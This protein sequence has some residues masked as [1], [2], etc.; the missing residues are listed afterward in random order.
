MWV[1]GGPVFVC[2]TIKQKNR[3][4]K[5]F[6]NTSFCCD[7]SSVFS[8]FVLK[9]LFSE[10]HSY[11]FYVGLKNILL[12]LNLLIMEML[13]VRRM[14]NTSDFY[15]DVSAHFDVFIWIS[16]PDEPPEGT[17]KATNV[18]ITFI[19]FYFIFIFLQYSV[20]F[21]EILKTFFPWLLKKDEFIENKW[22]ITH[23]GQSYVYKMIKW[24]SR[25]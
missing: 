15:S 21:K 8:M 22:R 24:N 1:C 13:S 19:V 17:K 16:G 4:G 9:C 14:C 11:I 10:I 23:L 7:F 5:C 3:G 6:I 18:F 2:F 20:D 12:T 25:K